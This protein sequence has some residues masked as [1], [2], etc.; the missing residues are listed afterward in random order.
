MNDNQTN[1]TQDPLRIRAKKI[2]GFIIHLFWFIVIN[3]FLYFLDFRENGKIDWAYWT[4]FG[5]G[6]GILSHAIGVFG[7]INLEEK[8]YNQLKK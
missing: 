7:R 6:I 1:S 5:W 2:T 4:T 8:V 3:I